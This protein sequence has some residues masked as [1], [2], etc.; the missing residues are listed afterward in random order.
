MSIL[1]TFVAV[2]FALVA[3]APSTGAT[4]QPSD[5]LGAKALFYNAGGAV[6]SVPSKSAEP[7]KG[8]VAAPRKAPPVLALRAS[9]LLVSADGGTREV[10]PSHPFQS[11]DRIKLSFTA[12]RSGHFYLATVGSSGKVQILAPRRGEQAVLEAGYRYQYPAAQNSY[13]KFDG[14]AG[15]EVLW[16]VL[17]DEPLQAINLGDGRV[18]QVNT[19]D[20]KATGAQAV[21]S[22]SDEFAGKDLVFEEDAE[23]AYA[24]VKPSAH[25][26]NDQGSKP[27][28]MV[29]LVLDHK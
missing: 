12:N 1:N 5:D 17:A 28:V 9:V 2:A 3:F 25:R 10:K 29:K 15:K 13:F 24:S 4:Q 27:R 19:G 16:A 7:A 8:V 23:A 14:Q 20:G 18:A 26:R 22:V 11:G 6:V 21:A